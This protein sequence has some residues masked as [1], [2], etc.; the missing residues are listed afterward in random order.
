MRTRPAPGALVF[1]ADYNPEQW[2]A[3]TVEEDVA[4]M[5]EAGVNRVSLGIFAWSALEPY[6]GV[7]DDAWFGRVLD[8]LADADIGVNLA[9]PT[10][11]PPPW[12]VRAHPE[13][14]LEDAHG[15][16]VP[17]GGRLSWCPS[18]DVFSAQAE[19]IVT[20]V[21]ETFGDHPAVRLWHVSNELG[22]ENAQ[23]FCQACARRFRSWLA[24][25]YGDVGTL[26]EAWGTAFWGHGL[27]SFDD[28]QSPRASRNPPDPA[29]ALD[30]R[31]FCSD[32]LLGHYRHEVEILRRVTPAV[33]VTTNFM[34]AQAQDAVDYA[35]WRDHVDLVA[36]DHYTVAA[37]SRRHV[38]LALSADR[39]RGLARGEPWLLMEHSTSA[40][41][42]QARNRTK[43]PGEMLRDSLTHVARGADG[44]MFFQWRASLAGSEQFHSAMLPHAGTGTRV[45]REVVELGDVL[46]RLAPVQGTRVER[47]QVVLLWDVP[48]Q[49]A[50][51]AARPPSVDVRYADVP[52]AA[53]TALFDRQV[54]VD[55]VPA[56]D[57]AERA[58]LD[59]RRVIVVPTT[60]LAH[61]GL[62]GR[63][64]DAAR[65]GAH[66]VVTA[67]SGVVDDTARVI[68]GG[69]PGAFRGLL[70]AWS[71]EFL[72]LQE[73][74][75]VDLDDGSVVRVWTEHVHVA[76]GTEVVAAYA[77][78][79]L[80]GLPA[81]TRR[82]LDEGTVTYVSCVLEQAALARLLQDVVARAGVLPVA[83]AD[84]GIDLVR[85]SGQGRSFLFCLSHLEHAGKVDVHG[86][87]LVSG[88]LLSGVTEIQA[89]GVL[90]VDEVP[91]SHQQLDGQ[92]DGEDA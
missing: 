38:E 24:R 6:P 75:T 1:G 60:Y 39:T 76:D 87:D 88:R 47:A 63:L 78:G 89:G 74:E 22:N 27:S 40:V 91:S 18:S 11:S 72:P 57:A 9:T 21:A 84:A 80:S 62:A 25:R 77:S 56:A 90:V 26:N 49:W 14:Q 65:R 54:A 10:A 4:L 35:T 8:R 66:V 83:A 61:S 23:C 85:R 3:E 71:E 17:A 20:H 34:V 64:E 13:M 68:P 79:P 45:W 31:R 81:I 70:G 2:P 67:L 32:A 51:E 42:W 48:S 7:Y 86:R 30:Y 82:A 52:A 43:E 53:Y 15:R 33:P 36:N 29:L 50:L 41:N 28:V 12:L 46:R 55:V 37:D 5:R 73:H 58:A 69:Y 16:R 59:D 92:L 44:A 19:R